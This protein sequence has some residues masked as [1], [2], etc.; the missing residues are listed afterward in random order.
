[1]KKENSILGKQFEQKYNKAIKT[2]RTILK[3][4]TELDETTQLSHGDFADEMFELIKTAIDI[5]DSDTNKLK[6][7]HLKLKL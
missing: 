1:M 3:D 7:I 4:L 6:E 2:N 5:S